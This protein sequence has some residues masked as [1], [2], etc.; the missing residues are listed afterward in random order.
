MFPPIWHHL[1]V[2]QK[3]PCPPELQK[4]TWRTGGILTWLLM[5]DLHATFTDT[6]E[7]CSLPSDIISRSIRNVNVLLDS[8]KKLG[9]QV[10]SLH[11]SWC[12]ILMPLSQTLQIDVPSHLTSSPGP[13]PPRLQEKNWRT[14]GVLTWFL[15]SGLDETFTDTSGKCSRPSDTISRSIRNIHVLLESRKTHGGQEK[16]WH[17][18]W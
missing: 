13:C 9:V 17:G 15:M 6:S 1:Q 10:E 18:C 5:S 11:G 4:E 7:R 14:D 12:Q 2:H 16:S 8:R 3:C